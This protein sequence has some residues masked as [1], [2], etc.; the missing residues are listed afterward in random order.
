[1][2]REDINTLD[3]FAKYLNEYYAAPE[4]KEDG[5]EIIEDICKEHDGWHYTGDLDLHYDDVDYVTDYN[6]YLYESDHGFDTMPDDIL[7]RIENAYADL[8]EVETTSDASGYPRGLGRAVVGFDTFDEAQEVADK[9]GLTVVKLH[10]RDG[11]QLWYND[12]QKMYDSDR[13]TLEPEDMG[14]RT[15]YQPDDSERVVEDLKTAIAGLDDIECIFNLT[16]SRKEI[17]EELDAM[18][19]DEAIFTDHDSETPTEWEK[20][21]IHPTEWE[22][23]THHYCVAVC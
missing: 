14:Y 16:Q 19:N 23:D 20:V 1:M 9:Y 17:I 5:T 13:P 8:H 10:R 7:E 4:H 11:W 22:Y 12:G 21:N 3:D 18:G 6:E 15:M 2:K